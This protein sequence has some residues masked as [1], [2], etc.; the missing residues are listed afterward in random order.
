MVVAVAAGMTARNEPPWSLPQPPVFHQL[1]RDIDVDVAIVGAGIAGLSTAYFLTLE[2]RSVAVLD[3]AG[4]G[5]GMTAATTGHLSSA[6]DA[7]FFEI[8]RLHGASSARRVAES[9]QAAIDAVTRIVERE[10]IECGLERLPG[11]LFESPAADPDV[12]DSEVTAARRAGLAVRSLE[13]TPGL[14]T[15]RCL[16][17]PQQGQFHPLRYLAGLVAA[18]RRRGGRFYRARIEDVEGGSPARLRSG[19]RTVVCQ[20][21][22]VATNAPIND[23]FAVHAQQAPFMTYAIGLRMPAGALPHALYWD[24]ED[25]YHYLRVH[26]MKGAR[27][28]LPGWAGDELLIVG[29][30]D[31]RTGQGPAGD[32]HARL[33]AWTRDHVPEARE[34]AF[35][36]GGQVMEALDGLAMI[37]RNPFDE[38]NVYVASGDCGMGLTHGTIAGLLLPALIAGREHPWTEVYDPRRV[39]P[40]AALRFARQ[41]VEVAAQYAE[42]ILPGSLSSAARLDRDSGEILQRGSSKIAVYRDAAGRL[43]ERSAICTHLGC[44]VAWNPVEKSWDCPCH[45]SRFSPQGR[46]FTGPA[47]RDLELLD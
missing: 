39:R 24:T 45:G 33:E 40:A 36:W 38:E 7:R 35:R 17:F 42:R 5:A 8:E 12:L 30:E 47:N 9:H 3:A 41:G 25:P 32:P 23:R 27:G 34:V 2:G 10:R 26:P 18:V 11:Y 43:H 4:F 19:K 6:I 44:V 37:G 31:H 29:G 21:A 1:R 22:V 16:E 46:V 20:A 28:A 15:R 14:S 13:A